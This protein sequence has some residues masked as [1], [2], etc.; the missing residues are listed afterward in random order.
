MDA[1]R[2]AGSKG[3]PPMKR[4]Q[5]ILLNVFVLIL[6]AALSGFLIRSIGTMIPKAI[7]GEKA[8]FDLKLFLSWKTWLY[9]AMAAFAAFLI[10]I[11]S[12]SNMDSLLFSNNIHVSVFTEKLFVVRKQEGI[13]IASG[14]DPDEKSRKGSHGAIQPGLP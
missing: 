12:G 7:K 1:C 4:W 5:K 2:I 6:I 13:H 14:K 3:G 10:W 8:G 9:G 11:L